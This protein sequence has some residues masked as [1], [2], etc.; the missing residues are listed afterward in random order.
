[1]NPKDIVRSGYDRVSYA[2][3]TESF[4]YEHSEYK[5]FLSW[6]AARLSPGAA[7]LDLGCGCG[8]PVAQVLSQRYQVT[9]VDISPVQIERAC[10][11]VPAAQFICADMTSLD[12]APGGFEA[13]VAFFSIIH[14][15]LEEQPALF[16]KL[17]QWLKPAGY[18]LASV[19]HTAWT[20]TE[21]H[22]CG[23]NDATMYWS[24]READAYRRWFNEVGLLIVREGFLLEGNGSH[25]ILLG[26]KAGEIRMSV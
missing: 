2:Y 22:W 16:A 26:Q 19:G 3:R 7:V 10:Q 25:T 13:A 4:D 17:V 18:L 21:D 24:H 20:G 11:L 8:I 1:M 23:V 14:V 6:L 15:P 5:H 9:G 12:L